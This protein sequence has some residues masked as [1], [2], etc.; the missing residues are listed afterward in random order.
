MDIKLIFAIISAVIQATGYLFYFRDI[1]T[2]KSN[3][4]AYSW[5]IWAITQTTAALGVF[6]GNGGW[7][8]TYL[9]L[10]TLFVAAIFFLS[11]KF[12][13][14]NITRS[15]TVVL[16]TALMAIF[17]WWQLHQPVISILMVTGIDTLGS[18]PSI[19]KSFVEPWSE[20]LIFWLLV[21][22][23]GILGVLAIKEYNFMSTFYIVISVVAP[24]SA[25]LL[26]CF[27]RRFF[28]AEPIQKK[29]LTT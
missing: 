18:V 5:L 9:V 20:T 4:H 25:I 8:G 6:Y 10:N 17:V 16:I 22:I 24:D 13:T 28:V 19:R 23:A 14:K 27:I 21:T 26:I 12:G 29:A 11:L 15:D 3:P 7:G 1:V 2:K